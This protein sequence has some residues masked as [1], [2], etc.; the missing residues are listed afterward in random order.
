MKKFSSITLLCIVGMFFSCS[1]TTDTPL[2]D[3]P[4]TLTVG[5]EKT[6]RIDQ[7]SLIVK[8]VKVT[9][10]FSEGV[11]ELDGTTTFHN[12]YDT[13]LTIDEQNLTF[14]SYFETIDK[15]ARKEKTWEQLK[16]TF[17]GIIT[18][19]SFQI[20]ISDVYSEGDPESGGKYFSKVL[21]KL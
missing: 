11:V 2:Q 1:D 10:I 20:G 16:K 5:E 8:L 21:I 6:V 7:D 18:Y 12:V 13:V 9:P 3:S 17:E 19:K 4:I 14:R 15:Q